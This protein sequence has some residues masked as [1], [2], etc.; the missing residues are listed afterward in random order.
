MSSGSVQ[1]ISRLN[2]QSKFQIFTLHPFPVAISTELRISVPYWAL[3]FLQNISTITQVCENVETYHLENCLLHL[4]P[5]TLQFLDSPRL[6]LFVSLP[7]R[8]NGTFSY[9]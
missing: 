8:E 6:D 7:D 1:I 5:I 4:S 2:C 3:L 9:H